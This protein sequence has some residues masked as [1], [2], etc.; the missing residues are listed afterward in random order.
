MSRL[1]VAGLLAVW[2]AAACGNATGSAATASDVAT[3]AQDSSTDAATVDAVGTDADGTDASTSNGDAIG[4]AALPDDLA[5]G[6]DAPAFDVAADVPV[7]ACA[8][9]YE[10]S[11]PGA[12]LDLSKTPCSFSI[13]AAKGVFNLGYR[14][15][16]ATSEQVSTGG[17]MGGCPPQASSIHG[18]IATFEQ[19]DGGNQKWCMCD[20]GL[21]QAVEPPFVASTPGSYDVAFTWDGNNFMGPSDTGFKPGPAFPP[22]NYVFSVTVTGKHQ[23]ADGTT[24]TFSAVAK[25]P[26][27][28]TP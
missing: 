8:P 28:L 10:G 26:I 23:K 7:T 5:T 25:L 20:T 4:D 19:V 2:I 6:K 15:T 16:V 27:V 17:N 18:G 1:P 13:G 3:D 12:A 24:E 21:C 11:I 22:G 14:L 9:T